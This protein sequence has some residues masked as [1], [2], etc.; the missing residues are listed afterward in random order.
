MRKPHKEI[1]DFVLNENGLEAEETVFIDDSIQHVIGAEKSGI[2]A[3]HL[4][5]NRTLLDLFEADGTLKS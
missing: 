1:F 4:D 3:I 2:T 5:D